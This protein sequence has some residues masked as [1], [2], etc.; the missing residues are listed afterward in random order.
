[1][2]ECAKQ[3]KM[4]DSERVKS[5][6]ETEYYYQPGKEKKARIVNRNNRFRNFQGY[7]EEIEVSKQ[8][9]DAKRKGIMKIMCTKTLQEIIEVSEFRRS[10]T[11]RVSSMEYSSGKIHSHSDHKEGISGHHRSLVQLQS[12]H[13]V[14]QYG[15]IAVHHMCKCT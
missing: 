9:R 3:M 6:I 8:D 2:N 12:Q 1:M 11:G 4:S 15:R 13:L 7:A 10:A 14:L 5:A